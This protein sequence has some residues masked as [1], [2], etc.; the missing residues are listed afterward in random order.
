MGGL[1]E[2]KTE[3]VGFTILYVEDNRALRVNASKLL[4]KIFDTVNVASD[5]AEGLDFFQKEKPDIV[6]TDI[7]MPNMDGLELARHI[8]KIDTN[9]KV[10]VMSAFDDS[11]Y[12]YSA[13]ELG[14]FRYLKKPVNVNALSEVL[15]ATIKEIK[16]ERD[17]QIF[18]SHLHSIFNYQSSMILMMDNSI[19]TFANQMFLDYF[20]VETLDAFIEK[21]GDIGTLFLEHDGFIFNTPEQNWFDEVSQNPQRLYNIKLQD[22]KNDFKHYILK[23]QRIP[24]KDSYGILSFDDVTELNLLKLYDASQA[25]SDESVK[26]SKAMYKLLEVIQRNN[27]KVELHNFYKGISITHDA[28]ITEIK[29]DAIVLKT[30]YRQEKAIQYDQ[31]SF[32]TSDALPNIIACDNV[33]SISFEHQSVEFSEIH[34][35]FNSAVDR[36]GLRVVPDEKHT[37]TLFL[38]ETKF[39]GE[40]RIEDI[41]LEAVKLNLEAL[42]AG[43]EIG[44]EVSVNMVLTINKKPVIITSPAVMLRKTDN[45]RSFSIVF[46][47]DFK[48]GEKHKLVEYM[49]SR[50]MEIIREFKGLQN[51]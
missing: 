43:L 18:N 8:K 9:A 14:V 25:K 39:H 40:T 24:D 10:I 50:Q 48:V 7:K 15:L 5:G 49:T 32:I 12:L 4:S 47:F 45:K 36:R 30:D 51:A 13:I 17:A 28:V 31:R 19:P 34:F 6:I 11:E 26:N 27:A 42:P 21:H 35:V 29:E 22:K 38:G 37:A 20:E 16:S 33:E 1:Q 41:S 44:S 2:L 23:Y 46:T 3:A